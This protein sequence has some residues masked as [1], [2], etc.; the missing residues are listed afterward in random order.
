VGVFACDH[1]NALF[2]HMRGTTGSTKRALDHTG[3]SIVGAGPRARDHA[4]TE[5]YAMPVAIEAPEQLG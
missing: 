5:S 1:G 4:M 3:L 2:A